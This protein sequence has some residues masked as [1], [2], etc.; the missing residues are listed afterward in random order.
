VTDLEPWDVLGF[1]DFG[2]D[3]AQVLAAMTQHGEDVLFA[4]A[5]E[6]VLLLN[7]QLAEITEGMISIA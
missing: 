7:M 2:L 3:E 1:R 5:D 4:A 6:A